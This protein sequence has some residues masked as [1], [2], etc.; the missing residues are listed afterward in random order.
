MIE[1]D[2]LQLLDYF[3]TLANKKTRW[4]GFLTPTIHVKRAQKH[5]WCEVDQNSSPKKNWTTLHCIS[6]G[7]VV[8][9]L[10]QI[11]RINGKHAKH[12]IF[13]KVVKKAH[14]LWKGLLKNTESKILGRVNQR[15]LQFFLQNCGLFE[16]HAGEGQT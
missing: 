11:T 1:R 13:F 14:K 3:R 12:F 10:Q 4:K 15:S 5:P 16:T 7:M 6:S 2:T 8:L 9:P